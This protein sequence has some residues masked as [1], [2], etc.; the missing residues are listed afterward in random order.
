MKTIV[1]GSR[2]VT[3]PSSVGYAV[4]ACGWD[5]TE[6]VS[7]GCRGV[8]R[9][10]ESLARAMGFPL[11]VFPADWNAHGKAAGPIRNRQMARYADAL[12]LIWDGKSRGSASMKRE[13]EAA[14]LVVFEWIVGATP[15]PRLDGRESV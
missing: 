11:K 1:A 15:S 6:I 8:D 9:M 5:I 4:G 2:T 13:A 3:D 7:G 12:V 10:G 14:G